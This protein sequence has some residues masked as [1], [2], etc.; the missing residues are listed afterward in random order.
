MGLIAALLTQVAT[1]TEEV[2]VNGAEAAALAQE[3][4]ALLR[5]DMK[6]YLQSLNRDL[7]ATV[8]RNLK[9]AAAPQVS[10]ALGEAGGR[11]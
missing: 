5:T 11:G 3:D 9:R 6:E 8:E 2:V 1:A 10:L 4:E 7:K